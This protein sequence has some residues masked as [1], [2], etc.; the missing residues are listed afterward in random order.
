MTNEYNDLNPPEDIEEAISRSIPFVRPT[1]LC[2]QEHKDGDGRP[3]RRFIKREDGVLK[4]GRCV[5]CQYGEGGGSTE[6]EKEK[7]NK[8]RREREEVTP[9]DPYRGRGGINSHQQNDRLMPPWLARSKRQEFNS[10]NPGHIDHR[11]I[12]RDNDH[13]RL[14]V[15]LTTVGNIE[16][17]KEKP[18]GSFTWRGDD[19][20]RRA[21]IAD[22]LAVWKAHV[23]DDWRTDWRYYLKPDTFGGK[24]ASAF[25]EKLAAYGEA[26][27]KQSEVEN[28]DADAPSLRH[29]AGYA[30][31][32]TWVIQREKVGSY[33]LL[34]FQAHVRDLKE[35]LDHADD[36]EEYELLALE[37]YEL[38][39]IDAG[40][41]EEVEDDENE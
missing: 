12:P 39:V 37:L 21:A 38:G 10:R 19:Q 16:L 30:I 36:E 29:L 33:R 27:F 24:A 7:V 32:N 34:D 31:E 5:K 40:Y 17:T 23:G 20:A 11:P 26:S 3:S 22:G 18:R 8:R 4:A 15:G 9:R 13:E 2:H 6:I 41:F 35:A 1:W 14:I 25:C 28:V